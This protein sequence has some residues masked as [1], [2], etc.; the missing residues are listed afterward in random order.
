MAPSRQE[1]FGG[2]EALRRYT[3]VPALRIGNLVWISG[4]TATDDNNNVVGND[5][6]EQTRYIFQ[7]FEMLLNELGGSC[8]DIVETTDYFITTDKY[9]ETAAVRKEVFG[10]RKPTS[11]G[12]M[13]AGLLRP[14]ALIEISATALIPDTT[15]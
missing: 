2:R 11:T 4:T 6:V 12:V 5:I 1:A 7:R 8:Q 10:D 15:D 13:V 3:Y 14:G 9:R